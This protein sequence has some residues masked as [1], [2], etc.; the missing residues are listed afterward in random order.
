MVRRQNR[1][2]RSEFWGCPTYPRC[3]GTRPIDAID[4]VRRHD[5]RPSLPNAILEDGPSRR[6][7]EAGASARAT[8]ERR[9][10]RHRARVQKRRPRT[11][12]IG[13]VLVVVGL[14]LVGTPTTWAFV[15]W[16]LV[17]LGIARTLALLFIEPPNVRAWDIGAGGEERLGVLLATLE[18]D[19]FVVLNDLRMPPSREN[20]DHLLIGPPGIFVIE[21]KTYERSVR[22][23]GGDLYI[24]GRRKT[25]FFDQVDRQL[26]AVEAALEVSNVRGFICVLDGDF[27][28]FGRPIARGIEVTP[29]KRLIET[30]R[31][32]PTAIEAPEIERLARLA[33][34][35]LR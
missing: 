4:S 1:R 27:P 9:L 31:S 21:T 35:R 18:G 3:R 22:V 33:G 34:E 7:A 10:E 24:K 23:R 13:A 28:W 19:G 26:A 6:R 15:G 12:I 2:D 29:P 17:L 16:P 30:V 8:Y 20:I 11:L 14:V 5:P 25:E 32:L